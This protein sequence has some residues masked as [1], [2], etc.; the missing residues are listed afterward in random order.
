MFDEALDAVTTGWRLLDRARELLRDAPA[1]RP[2]TILEIPDWMITLILVLII[3]ALA[4]MVVLNRYKKRLDKVFRFKKRTQEP[5]AAADILGTAGAAISGGASAEEA[6]A[7]RRAEEKEKVNKV[8]DLL[9]REYKEGIISEK[10]YNE[11]RKR[12]LDKPLRFIFSSSEWV[13]SDGDD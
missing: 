11:L 6:A 12:N 5:S 7:T 10:A 13:S 9:D 4:L 2:V 3:A 1:L 8:L